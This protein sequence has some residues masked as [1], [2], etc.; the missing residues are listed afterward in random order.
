MEVAIDSQLQDSYWMPYSEQGLSN[1]AT[2][3]F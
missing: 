1:S 2:I 3:I